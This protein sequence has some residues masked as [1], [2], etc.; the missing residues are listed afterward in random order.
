MP[1]VFAAGR[2][3]A[4][5][6]SA[7]SLRLAGSL[8]SS[9]LRAVGSAFAESLAGFACFMG[10][11]ASIVTGFDAAFAGA[12]PR[13]TT[14]EHPTAAQDPLWLAACSVPRALGRAEARRRDHLSDLD[15]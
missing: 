14:A 9:L 8:R 11:K 12:S 13:E 15:G 4:C 6:R 5:F 1:F 2:F 7:I 3:A 10:P